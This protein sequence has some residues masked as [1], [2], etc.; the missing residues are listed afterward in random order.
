[1]GPAGRAKHGGGQAYLSAMARRGIANRQVFYAGDA[2]EE[3]QQ[4]FIYK[5]NK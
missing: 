2:S 3:V 4:D 5:R 1:M